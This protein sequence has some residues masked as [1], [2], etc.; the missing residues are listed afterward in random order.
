MHC[1]ED[2]PLFVKS[3]CVILSPKRTFDGMRHHRGLVFVPYIEETAMTLGGALRNLCPV[4]FVK[5]ISRSVDRLDVGGL[6]EA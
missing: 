4:M 2:A 1:R 3:T 6:I 5:A